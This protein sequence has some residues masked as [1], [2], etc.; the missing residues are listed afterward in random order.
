MRRRRH[1][2]IVVWVAAVLLPPPA[3]AGQVTVAVASNFM[4]PMQEV[5]AAFERDTG[6]EVTLVSG[7]TG[8]LYAQIRNGAPF[9]VLLAADAAR[10][11]ALVDAGLVAASDRKTY[12]IGKLAFW[13]RD[14]GL[15]L[16]D[17]SI[18]DLQG[19]SQRLAIA[20]PKLAPYGHAAVEVLERLGVY[21]T[22]RR[23]LVMG[24]N[25]NQSYQFVRTGNA[26]FGFVAASLVYRDG[27][28]ERGSAWLVPDTWH[29]PVRQD[30]VLLR[31][32][33][34]APRAMFEYLGAASTAAVLQRFGY[35]VP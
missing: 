31:G 22:L 9:D 19:Q 33:N 25:V 15:S 32:A 10:P 27:A 7:S 14:A 29:T 28:L 5:V 16:T 23:Q 21:D 1:F 4:L 18:I 35:G 12:A 13:T 3:L 8:A 20:N 24:Q 30:A 17:A 34:G 11:Q 2:G 26:R 6:H